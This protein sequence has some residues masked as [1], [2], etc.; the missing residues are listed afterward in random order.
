MGHAVPV[1][2]TSN[3]KP[4]SL[5]PSL[6]K[7]QRIDTLLN[8]KVT[9]RRGKIYLCEAINISRAG[10]M[11]SCDPKLATQLLP[12]A[13]SPAPGQGIEALVEFALPV[14]ASQTVR[15]TAACQIVH[16]RRISRTEFHIGIRFD[17]F[18]DNGYDCLEQ[19]I[20]RCFAERAIG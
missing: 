7:Q 17:S 18:E 5:K 2:A 19:Y 4:V 12:D 8:I 9:D 11:I 3:M 13:R 15:I 1:L 20:S 16:L 6:R 10:M 14:D